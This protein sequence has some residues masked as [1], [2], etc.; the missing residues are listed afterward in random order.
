[1]ALAS[2]RDGASAK[3]INIKYIFRMKIVNLGTMPS[4]VNCYMAQLRDVNYQKNRTL[5][6]GNL[7]RIGHAMAYELSRTL[8]AEG[9]ADTAG[10]ETR[11]D[12]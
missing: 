12:V 10:R 5:F 9:G 4:V 2:F 6:R 1:M 11:A 3:I 8:I 7:E